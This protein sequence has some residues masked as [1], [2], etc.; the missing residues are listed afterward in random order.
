MG[1]E[2][3]LVPFRG[4]PLVARVVDTM[5]AAADEV[6][7]S[8]APGMTSRYVEVLGH[9]VRVVEDRNPGRGPV[10]GLVTSFRAAE[11][12]IVAT[13]PCDTP[14]LRRELV[15]TVVASIG[16]ADVAVPTVGGLME[17]LHAAYRRTVCLRAFEE[18]MARGEHKIVSAYSGLRVS[19]ID[20]RRLR[21]VDPDLGSFWNL[22]SREDLASAE[23]RDA[24]V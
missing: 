14:F 5:S 17:P 8:V 21:A 22:N 10:E 20:E 23:T 19:T 13:S 18:T 24:G 3:G 7:V 9:G 16:E 12:D 11:G 4:V 1:S 15:K 6:I 2:K